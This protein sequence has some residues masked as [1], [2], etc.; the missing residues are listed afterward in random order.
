MIKLI[1]KIIVLSLSVLMQTACEANMFTKKED[2]VLFSAI[3]GK[4][5]V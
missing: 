4:V 2:V 3:R 1:V 5:F